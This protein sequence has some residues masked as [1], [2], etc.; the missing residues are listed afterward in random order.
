MNETRSVQ[1]IFGG[2]LEGRR[3]RQRPGLRRTDDVED[4]FTEAGYKTVENESI[5]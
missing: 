1:K 4:V 5:G 3:G 2:K